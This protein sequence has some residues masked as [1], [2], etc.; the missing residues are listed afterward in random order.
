M[1]FDE[2]A[3]MLVPP[4]ILVVPEVCVTPMS[5]TVHRELTAA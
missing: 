2:V 1:Y 4:A 3:E 5:P